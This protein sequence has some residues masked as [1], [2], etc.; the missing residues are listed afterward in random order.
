MHEKRQ[1][2]APNALAL[3]PSLVK[4]TIVSRAGPDSCGGTMG[5]GRILAWRKSMAPPGRKAG[6]EDKEV[7]AGRNDDD[8][9]LH[10]SNR[11]ERQDVGEID[12]HLQ[13]DIVY[14]C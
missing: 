14:I 8:G 13:S 6:H 4:P 10:E 7:L 3:V 12:Q 2:E 1:P 9:P 5:K 11:S